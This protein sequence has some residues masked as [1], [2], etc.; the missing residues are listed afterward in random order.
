MTSCYESNNSDVLLQRLAIPYAKH[1][2]NPGPD[3]SNVLRKRMAP[4]YASLAH[5]PPVR[6]GQN[7]RNTLPPPLYPHIPHPNT[8]LPP[9]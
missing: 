1:F 5:T 3:V 7:H 4:P 9:L 6:H 2:P 8:L